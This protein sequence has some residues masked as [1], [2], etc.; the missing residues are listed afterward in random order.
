MNPRKI[1]NLKVRYCAMDVATEQSSVLAVYDFASFPH[2]DDK[3][4]W[5]SKVNQFTVGNF[6]FLEVWVDAASWLDAETE[7]FYETEECHFLI[8]FVKNDGALAISSVVELYRD[9]PIQIEGGEAYARPIFGIASRSVD[10]QIYLPH[11]V[12]YGDFESISYNSD[13][14]ILPIDVDTLGIVGEPLLVA[15]DDNYFKV[16]TSAT[17][18]VCSYYDNFFDSTN[19][20]FLIFEDGNILPTALNT[21][22][23]EGLV[24]LLRLKDNKLF[25]STSIVDAQT[26][27]SVATAPTIEDN[28]EFV[29]APLF[30]VSEESQDGRLISISILPPNTAPPPPSP[31]PS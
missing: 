7:T 15:D 17:S 28:S 4:S 27:E 22:S 23:L 6:I 14:W 2:V 9:L 13:V 21:F 24:P 30:N 29:V 18:M 1:S 8:K 31:K 5:Y 25:T 12:G 19:A 10:S 3:F 16:L 26:G 20:T 11:N